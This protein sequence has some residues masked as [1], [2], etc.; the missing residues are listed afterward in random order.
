[1]VHA[2]RTAAFVAAVLLVGCGGASS[3]LGSY[4][5]GSITTDVDATTWANNGSAPKVYTASTLPLALIGLA[6]LGGE[7]ADPN[8]PKKTTDGNTSRWQG[9]CTDKNGTR[10]LGSAEQALEAAGSKTGRVTYNGFGF[11]STVNCNDKT[12]TSKLTFDGVVNVSGTQ[13]ETHFDIDV[14]MDTDGLEKETCTAKTASAAYDYSGILKQDGSNKATW[15]G[16]GRV[17]N[18]ELGVV[19]VETKDEVIDSSVCAS[20]ALSGTTTIN[21]GPNTA[22]ITYDGATDCED[23]STVGWA[24]NGESKGELTGVACT[25]AAGPAALAWLGAMIG[26]LPLLRRRSKQ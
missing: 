26:A 20:E 12:G 2:I 6:G 8:C 21:A 24:L 23:S 15:N 16:S 19:S 18:S 13:E 4:K 22:V 11:E 1:M 25:A 9:D 10:W 7:S 5:D 17:G 14:R 3:V